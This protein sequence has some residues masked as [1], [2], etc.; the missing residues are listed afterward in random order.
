MRA[1]PLFL[2]KHKTLYGPD[3]A[4]TSGRSRLRARGGWCWY[5]QCQAH[6]GLAKVL[7]VAIDE[8]A[9]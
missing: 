9:V 6:V 4:T 7:E 8:V 1:D 5:K 3:I 2:R